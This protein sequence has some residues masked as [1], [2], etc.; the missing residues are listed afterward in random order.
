M[1]RRYRSTLGVMLAVAMLAA[2]VPAAAFAIDPLAIYYPPDAFEPDNTPATATDYDADMEVTQHNLHDVDDVDWFKFSAEE[3]GQP[4]L[5]ESEPTAGRD[6]DLHMYVYDAA[7]TV[8]EIVGNDDA[9]WNTYGSRVY[10]EAPSPG[11]YYLKVMVHDSD[12]NGS[13]GAYTLT[14]SDGIARRIY[15]AD[16]FDTAVKVSKTIWPMTDLWG[17]YQNPMGGNDPYDPECIVI[18]NG[19]N[20]PDALAGSAF[21]A[22]ADGVLLLTRPDSL[23]VTTAAEMKRLMTMAYGLDPAGISYYGMKVYILGG[24]AAVNQQVEDQIAAMD[25]VG[26]VVRLSGGTRYETAVEV[27]SEFV[28]FIGLGTPATAFVVG[29]ANPWDALA[30]SPVAA[31]AGAP[32]LLSGKSD[33]PTATIDFLT[34]NAIERVVVVGGLS[35]LDAT[36]FAEL[37]AAVVDVERVAGATRYETAMDIAQWGVDEAGMDAGSVVLASGTSFADGLAAAPISWYS[38]GPMLLTRPDYL[39]DEVYDFFEA[40]GMPSS[41]SYVVGGPAAV[42]D[43]VYWEFKVGV[44]SYLASL[45]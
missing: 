25:G 38:A 30:A 43:D 18:S 10:F 9:L 4:F 8:N 28:D 20:W 41:G 34:D 11:D 24:T 22:A 42:H 44:W 39:V 37:D 32:V 23:P 7:D 33:V 13:I 3:T 6:I 26:E 31:Y 5:L 29:G 19:L 14:V 12:A 21:A 40:N 45:P 15:G 16:R 36:A 17:A 2:L 1:L 35:T 27:G